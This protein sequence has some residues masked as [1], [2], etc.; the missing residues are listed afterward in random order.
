VAGLDLGELSGWLLLWGLALGTFL[1]EDLACI[2]GGFLVAAGKAPFVSVVAACWVGIVVGDLLLVAAGRLIGRRVLGWWPFRNWIDATR[3]ERAED[4][5]ARHGAKVV[6]ASRF[7]PGTRLATYVAAGVLR[8]PWLPF[9]G[10][11]ILA[12]TLWTPLLVG[13]AVLVGEPLLRGF[14]EAEWIVP[15]VALSAI[16]LLGAV[17]VL[18][19]IATWRGRRLLLSRWRRLTRWEYWPI[20]AVYLPVIPWIVGCACRHRSLG[21]VTAANPG[22]GGAG[23]LIGESKIDILRAFDRPDDGGGEAGG[24]RVAPWIPLEPGSVDDRLDRIRAFVGDRGGGW[25][26]VLKPEHGERGEGVVIARTEARAREAVAACPGRL[27]AQR[28][29]DG[30]EYGVFYAR[31]P[32]WTAG[33]IWA[34]TDKRRV[35]VEGDGVSTLERLIL[36]DDRAVGMAAFYLARWRDDLGRVPAPG[37]RVTLNELGTH[38]RGALFLD[39]TALVTP[40][41]EASIDGLS[42]RFAGFHFGRYDVKAE[43]EEA[44]RRGEVWILE[45]NGL[46]SEA[47]SMYDPRHRVWTGW[48]TL[49][50]QWAMAYAIGAANRAR[51][52]RPWTVGEVGRLY[53]EERRRTG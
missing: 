21:V 40:E 36:A 34:V 53:C 30:R 29:I 45:L 37:E 38:C 42:R 17:R 10:W 12:A 18:Q 1:S 20:W 13:A 50:R 24:A 6:L 49:M 14:R 5:I 16:A 43:S 48:A 27:I 26:V 23:G 32:E 44:F 7:A 3:L 51:G 11:F 2:S 31:H 22:M 46:T 39:G 8:A 35:R 25:P 52:V 41:L 33:R 47:T 9:T 15:L 19:T 28:Y 4:W